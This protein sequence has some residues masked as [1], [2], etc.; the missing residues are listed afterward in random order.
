MESIKTCSREQRLERAL[1]AIEAF[2]AM[3]DQSS[4]AFDRIYQIAHSS[5]GHCGNKHL[6][7]LADIEECEKIGADSKIYNV[8][9]ILGNIKV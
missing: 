2:G 6:D 4:A 8:E 1:L 5:L 7:W 3:D 9:K